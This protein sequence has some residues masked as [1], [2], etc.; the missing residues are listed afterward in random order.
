MSLQK[1]VGSGGIARKA[2]RVPGGVVVGRGRRGWRRRRRCCS[3]LTT[4]SGL[5]NTNIRAEYNLFAGFH[6]AAFPSRMERPAREP[7]PAAGE[8]QPPADWTTPQQPR[9][10]PATRRLAVR[11]RDCNGAVPNLDP[12][13]LPA[14]PTPFRSPPLPEPCSVH[15]ASPRARGG[16]ALRGR[17]WTPHRR[18]A[19]RRGRRR[20]PPP[21]PP[22]PR[23]QPPPPSTTT[24]PLPSLATHRCRRHPPPPP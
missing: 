12:S 15:R 6:D 11:Y 10:V 23:P 24:P 14:P 5:L 9:H 1:G 22:L 20:R 13:P 2:A 17:A 18:R 3:V 8:M 21:P 4:R 7:P 16:E 19:R